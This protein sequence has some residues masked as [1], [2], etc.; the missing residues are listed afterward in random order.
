LFDKVGFDHERNCKYLDYEASGFQRLVP[1]N[2]W[3]TKNIIKNLL[4]F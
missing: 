3:V 4:K 1:Q 2:P